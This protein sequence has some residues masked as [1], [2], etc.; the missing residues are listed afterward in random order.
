VLLSI[1]YPIAAIDCPEHAD[2]VAFNTNGE[3]T[4]DPLMGELTV[5][6]EYAGAAETISARLDTANRY[7][8]SSTS[9]SPSAET[10]CKITLL[11]K[12]GALLCTPGTPCQIYSTRNLWID[13]LKVRDYN[14]SVNAKNRDRS[15]YGDHRHL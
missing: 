14:L 11:E 3:E 13:D 6:L 10:A 7:F 2:A 15:G 4:C 12:A 9:T 8:I 5:T 1:E